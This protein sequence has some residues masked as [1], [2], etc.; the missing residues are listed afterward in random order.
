MLNLKYY[1]GSCNTRERQAGQIANIHSLFHKTL[2]LPLQ[3]CLVTCLEDIVPRL[4]VSLPNF[5]IQA[6]MQL[7][8]GHHHHPECAH[9][10]LTGC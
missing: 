7:N 6:L 4:G 3:M 9:H 10:L 2:W 8:W 5:C 1:A